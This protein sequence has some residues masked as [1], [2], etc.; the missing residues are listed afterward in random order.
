MTTLV[1]S[2]C[3][4]LSVKAQERA[5]LA[6]RPLE[7]KLMQSLDVG[8][9]KAG[10]PVFVKVMYDWESQGCRLRAGSTV[11]GRVVAVQ[12]H[13][14]GTEPPSMTLLFDR[15]DCNEQK[16]TSINLVLFSVVGAVPQNQQAAMVDSGWRSCFGERG[17]TSGL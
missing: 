17:A 9:V 2:G 6:E 7:T 14:Q 10:S 15:A 13:R 8:H 12:A 16:A 1:V 4:V 3:C 11:D 5:E